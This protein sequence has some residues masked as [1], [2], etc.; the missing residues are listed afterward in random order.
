MA[1]PDS[2]V[3][4]RILQSL[5]AVL[6]GLNIPFLCTKTHELGEEVVAS[7][8]R[9]FLIGRPDASIRSLCVQYTYTTNPQAFPSGSEPAVSSAV[10]PHLGQAIVG[11]VTMFFQ[12]EMWYER[13]LV[14][15]AIR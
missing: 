6:A 13:Y 10:W 9:T 4:D 12:P 8:S 5:I 11:T 7:Y 15:T 2:D 1:L 3:I 14:V